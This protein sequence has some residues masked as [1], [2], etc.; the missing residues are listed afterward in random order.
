M[1]EKKSVLNEEIKKEIAYLRLVDGYSVSKICEKIHQ[2]YGDHISNNSIRTFCY[3]RLPRVQGQSYTDVSRNPRVNK[4][5]GNEVHKLILMLKEDRECQEE[6]KKLK[7][8]IVELNKELEEYK[9]I[10]KVY[11]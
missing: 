3:Y 1:K 11:D 2:M 10:C 5:I 6:T 9:K 8:I 7:Q 4:D